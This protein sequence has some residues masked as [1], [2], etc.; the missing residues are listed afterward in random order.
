GPCT[1][2]EVTVN[3]AADN[4]PGDITWEIRDAGNNLIASGSPA[5]ANALNTANACLGSAT[6][7]CYSFRLFD[8]F[9]D[10]I[11]NGGWELRTTGGKLI[12]RDDFN[13][14]SQSPSATPLSPSYGPG[15][16]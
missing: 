12:L 3:I 16:S 2:D 1:G 5:T 9:G 6:G 13:G 15:H 8:N 7:G 4:A 10:G 11:T 14:G